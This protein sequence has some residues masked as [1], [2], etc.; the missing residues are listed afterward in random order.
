MVVSINCQILYFAY[1]GHFFERF[2]HPSEFSICRSLVI[3][4]EKKVMV[5]QSPNLGCSLMNNVLTIHR[6]TT[7]RITSGGI[8][9]NP[10]S[11][12]LLRIIGKRNFQERENSSTS[13]IYQLTCLKHTAV[14]SL[15]KLYLFCIMCCRLFGKCAAFYMYVSISLQTEY[16]C[17]KCTFQ[18]RCCVKT[19]R[20]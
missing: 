20:Q 13:M 15:L 5:K 3:L 11:W 4:K 17:W 1:T 2:L 6:H 19:K 9:K 18:Y 10:K 14:L 16:C 12:L 7:R 8:S